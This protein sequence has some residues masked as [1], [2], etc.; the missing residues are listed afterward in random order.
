MLTSGSNADVTDRCLELDKRVR[1]IVLIGRR[2]FAVRTEVKIMADSALVA[3]ATDVGRI[4][5]SQ[6]AEGS[7]A[8][9]TH[10]DRLGSNASLDVNQG[11]VNGSKAMLSMHKSGVGNAVAT[12]VPVGAIQA[13]VTNTSNI[14]KSMLAF[15]SKCMH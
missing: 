5:L 2:G 3:S 6:R 13:L 7:V 14:L 15:L 11:V 8:A 12:V 4:A 10:V 1:L 9:D